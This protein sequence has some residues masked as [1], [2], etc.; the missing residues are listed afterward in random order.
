MVKILRKLFYVWCFCVMPSLLLTYFL[1]LRLP[2]EVIVVGT[3]VFF[4]L[5]GGLVFIGGL[6]KK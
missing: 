3:I 4:I 6:L 2:E 1:K 5:L